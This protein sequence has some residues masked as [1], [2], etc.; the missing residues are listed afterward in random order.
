M[1]TQGFTFPPPPPPPPQRSY[2]ANT[3]PTRGRGYGGGSFRGRGAPR[4]SGFQQRNFSGGGGRGNSHTGRSAPV[5]TGNR[6][7]P[8]SELN[9]SLKRTYN[10][11]P[12]PRAPPAVPSFNAYIDNLIPPRPP[13][14]H[15]EPKP[16]IAK[17]TNLLGL[18]PAKAEASDS[19]DDIDEES[20][21]VNVASPD[22]LQFEYRGQTSTLRTPAEI[23]A[24][25]VERRKRWP[26]EEKREAAKRDVNEKQRRW[27]EEKRKKAE[28]IQ[29]VK[30]KRAEERQN[31][32]VQKK[33][34]K[35]EAQSPS[36]PAADSVSSREAQIRMENLRRKALKAQKKLE[37]AETEL[38]K[39]GTDVV[40]GDV[41]AKPTPESTVD[42]SEDDSSDSSD[43]SDLTDSTSSIESDSDTDS[44][45]EALSSKIE[46]EEIASTSRKPSR[47]K[48]PCQFFARYGTCKY[49]A[50]CKYSHDAEQ[51]ASRHSQIAATGSKT[52]RKGLWQVM[53]EKE[54][55]EERKKVLNVIIALGKQGVLDE[56]S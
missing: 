23:A 52:R 30:N 20:Q 11:Q 26:T 32:V 5:D 41:G 53:V 10:G 27:E 29:G 49:G 19:E 13:S 38:H 51:V 6:S 17:K 25:I 28:A 44:A 50:K 37:A 40:A 35:P 8:T 31:A 43:S 9:P 48:R 14:K 21:L 47:I 15:G 12:R 36:V 46:V 56:P 45:P 3:Q 2:D 54:Q 22:D 34:Q 33:P 7:T 16:P 42:D 18:T 4:G 55:E 1:S 39:A 24:W